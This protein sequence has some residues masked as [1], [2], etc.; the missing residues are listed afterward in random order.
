MAE[1][2]LQT[3]IF[4]A[5]GAYVRQAQAALR[6]A[7][8][9]TADDG[10]FGR[11]TETAVRDYQR[12]RGLLPDGVVGPRT[13]VRLGLAPSSV[14][15]TADTLTDLPERFGSAIVAPATEALRTPAPPGGKRA[16]GELSVS[17]HGLL[18]IMAEESCPTSGDVCWPGGRSGVTLGA[19]YDMRA[20][21]AH[22]IEADM[23]AI[24]IGQADARLM[25]LAAGKDERGGAA[26]AWVRGHAGWPGL[27]R[28]QQRALLRRVVPEY[29]A[30]VRRDVRAAL[31]QYQFDALV[32]VA[33]NPERSMALLAE[34]VNG[35]AYGDAV[36]DIL[37]R[38][39]AEA[40]VARGLRAR[41][42]RE[43]ALFLYG[44]YEGGAVPA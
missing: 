14:H 22:Q 19:G 24:G 42:E 34:K 36:K 3:I 32:S 12:A 25:G 9:P 16:C 17:E 39:G 20:R 27:T 35:G 30:V 13:A 4:G 2:Y 21:T 10:V 43:A 40:D 29:E 1:L 23:L 44:D 33:Y 18:F 15:L 26:Q 6:A 37:S 31:W 7:G 8:F 5:K 41:R 11:Q 28:P 38:V